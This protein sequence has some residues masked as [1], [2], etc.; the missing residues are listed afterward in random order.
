[1]QTTNNP[2]LPADKNYDYYN[3]SNLIKTTIIVIIS[4]SDRGKN[5]DEYYVNKH[6]K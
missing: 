1:M 2:T 3:A 4:K 5:Y 6:A